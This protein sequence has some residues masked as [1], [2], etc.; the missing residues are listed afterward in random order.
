MLFEK[1]TFLRLINDMLQYVIFSK[2]QHVLEFHNG[3]QK[4]ELFH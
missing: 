2:A 4:S 1:K 3:G